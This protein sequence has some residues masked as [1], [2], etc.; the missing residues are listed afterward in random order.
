M[1]DM[2]HPVLAEDNKGLL[3]YSVVGGVALKHLSTLPL[4]STKTKENSLPRHW[5]QGREPSHLHWQMPS[6]GLH[7]GSKITLGETNNDKR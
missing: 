5:P 6:E 7:T 4:N 3:L 2:M 1:K